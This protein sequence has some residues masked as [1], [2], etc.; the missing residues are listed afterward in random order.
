[1]LFAEALAT[2]AYVKFTLLFLPFRKVV[3]WLGAPVTQEAAAPGQGILAARVRQ[4]VRLCDRYAPWPTECYTRAL[5]AKIML[6]RRDVPSTLFFGF[7]RAGRQR[8]GHAWLQCA[9]VTV[10]GFC[11]L[12]EYEVHSRFN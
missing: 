11:D 1:L 12:S 8:R 3:A 7:S 6:G 5:T 9:G 4:A 2:S 10:T